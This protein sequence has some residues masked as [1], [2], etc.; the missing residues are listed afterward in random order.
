[1]SA[2]THKGVPI[3]LMPN[4][5]FTADTPNGKVTAASLDAIKKRLDK[6]AEFA[7]FA[8]FLIKGWN[9]KKIKDVTVIGT[10]KARRKYHSDEWQTDD[11]AVNAVYADTPEN[12]AAAQAYIDTIKRVTATKMA[13]D[14]ELRAAEAAIVTLRTT[15]KLE[16]A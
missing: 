3:T 5:K 6:P 13:L 15:D 9:E 7:P 11:G 8:A 14:D 1:M 12:R 10:V 2:F 4:G 16:A